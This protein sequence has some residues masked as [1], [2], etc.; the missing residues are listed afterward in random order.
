MLPRKRGADEV[1]EDQDEGMVRSD[2]DAEGMK[3]TSS[4]V[5]IPYACKH[6]F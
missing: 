3:P 2:L 6:S 4:G 5:S 1:E